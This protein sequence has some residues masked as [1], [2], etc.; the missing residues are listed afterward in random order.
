MG[1]AITHGIMF[2]IPVVLVVMTVGIYLIT[3]NSLG[4]SFA[5]S[6]LP[7]VLLGTFA[8]GFTGMASSMSQD[9]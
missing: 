5:T 8:G 1:H 9:H 4:E 3:D 7:G 6:V 2:G